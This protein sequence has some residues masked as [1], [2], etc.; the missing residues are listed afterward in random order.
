MAQSPFSFRIVSALVALAVVAVVCGS[1]GRWQLG[2]A[3]EREALLADITAGQAQPPLTLKADTPVTQMTNW[4]PATATG[5]W[6][7]RYTI[8]LANRNHE[9]RPGYWVAT[10]MQIAEDAT[11]PA[12]GRQ[13]LLV[14]RGWIPRPLGAGSTLPALD[15]P[16]G[17][18]TIT[19][20]LRDRV[21]RMFELSGTDDNALAVLSSGTSG[22][23]YPPEVQ[24]LDLAGVESV[25]GLKLVPAVLQQT[26]AASLED[27]T[28]LIQNWPTPSVDADKNRGY[29]VQ[30]FAF[31][32]IALGAW[33]VIAWRA[34][35]AWR[36]H[37]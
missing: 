12:V 28:P 9:G 33:L 25:T 7:N 19:G 29:A 20:S 34:L 35:R 24:N 22:P 5:Q 13:A 32:A 6:L 36:R 10:P 8:L 2:R 15:A 1:L 14:L 3:A 16:T 30:W 27:G 31:A 4:R 18:Q 23:T 26:S 11:Q 17:I 21:P 37:V